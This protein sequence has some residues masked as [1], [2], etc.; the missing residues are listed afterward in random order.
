MTTWQERT[1]IFVA[2][3]GTRMLLTDTGPLNREWYTFSEN[4]NWLQNYRTLQNAIYPGDAVLVASAHIERSAVAL[5]RATRLGR[6]DEA[7]DLARVAFQVAR[8]RTEFRVVFGQDTGYDIR[9]VYATDAY[10]M[11]LVT[12]I[13]DA[14]GSLDTQRSLHWIR[15]AWQVWEHGF[16]RIGHLLYPDGSDKIA[17]VS[18]YSALAMQ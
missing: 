7:L 16:C 3:V 18:G 13:S 2:N 17:V 5:L 4:G 8:R 12:A 6:G 10:N 9:E 15:S 11:T 14:P 1:E